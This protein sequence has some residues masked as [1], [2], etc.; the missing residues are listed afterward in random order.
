MDFRILGPVEV[1]EDGKPLPLGGP[2]QRALLALL[3]L[4]ANEAVSMDRLIDELWGADAPASGPTAVQN[5]IARLRKVLGAD[6]VETRQTG[7][8]IQV[9]PDEFD[10][11]RYRQLVDAAETAEPEQRSALLAQAVALWHGSSLSSLPDAPFVAAE[12]ARLEGLRLAALEE[13]IDADLELGRHADLVGELASLAARFPLQERL[14]GQL[15]LALYRSGRQAEALDVYRE[16]RR[17]LADELGLEPSQSLRE[18]ERAVLAQDPSLDSLAPPPKRRVVTVVPGSGERPRRKTRVAATVLAVGALGAAGAFAAYGVDRASNGESAKPLT[19]ATVRSTQPGPDSATTGARTTTR[20]RRTPSAPTVAGR[21]ATAPVT[22]SAPAPVTTTHAPAPAKRTSARGTATQ[23]TTARAPAQTTVPKKAQAP[24]AKPAPR[25]PPR[26]T[27]APAAKVRVF[28]IEDDF[29]SPE[30]DMTIWRPITDGTGAEVTEQGGQVAVTISAD[31]VPGG[32]A[33]AIGA[34]VGTQCTFPGD[35]D[36]RVEFTL[37]E[38]PAGAN[39]R[40][41]LNAFFV[42]GFVGRRSSSTTGDEYAARVDPREG[43]VQLDETSGSLRIARV[44]MLMTAYFWRNGRWVPLA[45]GTSSGAAVLGLQATAGTDFGHKRT[46][47]A[48]D[49]FVVT[50][51]KVFCPAGSKPPG[52]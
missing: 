19:S 33:N 4:H 42:G 21:P 1:V 8:A 20:P 44:G 14:R 52:A 47:A 36:A 40:V 27:T 5:Q 41:G 50:A 29:S 25:T 17:M 11:H 48:F 37:F 24:K 9:E 51:T 49:N 31:G 39:V 2:R 34:Q 28:R 10:L 22:T 23:V 45:S 26:A 38:W 16:T 6:R 7:Y 3:L 46:R 43:S 15:M 12:S 18:L 32:P 30:I 35:F 13:R